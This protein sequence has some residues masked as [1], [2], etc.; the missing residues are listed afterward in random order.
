MTAHAVARLQ[1]LPRLTAGGPDDAT[2]TPVRH[3]LG[4]GAFGVNAWHGERA[5]NLVIEDHDEVPGEDGCCAGHEE[6]YVV[7]EGRA[8]FV[9]D[10]EEI[11]APAGTLIAL[12]PHVRR[13]AWARADGTL[14]LA[15]GSPRGEPYAVS[16]WERRELANAGLV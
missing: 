1:D 7:V 8:R 2:W 12:P 13:A 16:P 3:A 11:D 15:V 10:G 4:I 9:V 6:L 14:I 5:G